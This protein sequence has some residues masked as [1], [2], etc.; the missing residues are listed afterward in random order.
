[1]LLAQ[2]KERYLRTPILRSTPSGARLTAVAWSGQAESLLEWNLDKHGL[3]LSQEQVVWQGDAVLALV[4][5]SD[6]PVPTLDISAER[7][8][9]SG[10]WS[11][12]LEFGH[13]PA[14][15]TVVHPDKKHTLAWQGFGVAAAPTIHVWDNGAWV[16]WHHNLRSDTH[17]PDLPKWIELRY[18][19][20]DGLVSC[21]FDAMRDCQLDREGIEQ[22]FEFPTLVVL[23]DGTV[24]VFG[25]GSHCFWWQTLGQRGWSE[26]TPLGGEPQWG[27][28]GRRVTA[29][30]LSDGGMLT[31]RREREGIVVQRLDVPLQGAP[32]LRA[33][34][35][36]KRF[37]V[38]ST[39]LPAAKTIKHAADPAQDDGRMTLFGDI[40]QHSAH[41][42]GCGSAEE[43]Y[44]RARDFYRD[45]F[46]ALSDHES[47]L[48]KRIGPGEWAYLQAVANAF[49]APGHFATLI[50]YEWT[51]KAHPGPG[52]KV[53]YTPAEGAPIISRDT[54][55]EGRALLDAVWAQ[56]GMAVPHHIGWTGANLDAHDP[57]KQPVWEICSSH[58]CYEHADHVLGQRGE[59][60]EQMAINALRQGLRFGFIACSDSHGLLWHHGV[61]RKRDSFRTGLT[62]VQAQTRTR[63]GILAALRERR[64]Y[65]TSGSKIVLDVRAAG[66]P[67]GSVLKANGPVD[68]NVRV[69]GTS[70]V[71]RV[72]LVGPNGDLS[73]K[74]G[75][76]PYVEFQ[77]PVHAA[78]VYARVEQ[79]D[80]E[81]AWSSPIFIEPA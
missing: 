59:L 50:A 65:A 58:G 63:Q 6:G 54:T 52:H 48:G 20:D 41:S 75:T 43:V 60:R 56:G 57:L 9:V 78:F 61:S 68:I 35:K 28:R 46:A 72:V 32:R 8:G 80:G 34:A 40:H 33:L 29:C 71:E 67:M 4:A 55:P 42:D 77:A 21:P 76:E 81:M 70:A 79:D 31:A 39:T 3:V 51:A 11:V 64:C 2:T 62:A 30:T 1:M 69:W 49:N 38:S 73:E 26:R 45:D 53:V 66:L 27:C 47:F 36:P 14:R 24:V 44:L 13:G 15:L 25:R 18:V 23:E 22:G 17:E 16:A 7:H 10:E 37:H 19:A 5:G 12:G 74:R